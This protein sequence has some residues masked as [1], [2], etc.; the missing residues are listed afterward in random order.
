MKLFDT[1]AYRTVFLLLSLVAMDSFSAAQA[2]SSV[3]IPEVDIVIVGGRVIDPESGLDA[4]R[5]VVI[6]DGIIIQLTQKSVSAK[7][8]IDATGLVVAPG[9]VDLHAHGQSQVSDRMQAF[10]GVTTTLEL[11]S[12]ILPVAEWYSNQANA[13]RV[14]NYGTS[15]AWTFARIQEFEGLPVQ[16]DLQWFREAFAKN[17][18]VN[19]PASPQQID[20]V[21]A[22]IDQGLQEGALGVGINGGYA[23]GGGFRELLAVHN[24]A[25]SYGVPTFTHASCDSPNDPDSSAECIGQVIALAASSNNHAHICHLNS[26]SLRVA[27]VTSKMITNAQKY[28]IPLSTE[29]YTYGA[30][31][32]TIGSALFTPEAMEAKGIAPQ[33]IE[34]NGKRLD[35]VSLKKLRSENPGAIV[36]LHFLDMPAERSIL[37]QSVLFPGGAIASD[38][39]PWIDTDTGAL[40][41]GKQWPLPESAFAHPRSAGTFSRLIAKWVRED[42][43]LSLPEAIRKATLIPANILAL[44]VPQMRKKGRIQ[45]GM[46]ADIIVFDLDRIEDKA[47]FSKPTQP[48]VGMAYVLVNGVPVIYQ[49]ELQLDAQPGRPIRREVKTG[50]VENKQK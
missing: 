17:H 13:G 18:W 37:D 14:L 32:T 40:V 27:D 39:M 10:D 42:K 12:G 33:D 19:D 31:S 9:F 35:A 41:D 25:A 8:I 1:L 26:S 44:S 24:L 47:T 30:S 36:V 15:A 7:R 48:A 22:A 45:V 3:A 34:L 4:Q 20:N 38:T 28:G 5:N 49:G 43:L 6:K 16:P 2:S 21:V 11:E 46:D 29:S 23:P 50:L